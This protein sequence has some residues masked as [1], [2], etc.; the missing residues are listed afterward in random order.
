MLGG[1]LPASMSGLSA[2]ES[3]SLDGSGFC[4]PNSPAMQT[5]VAAIADFT[6]AVCEGSASFSRMVTPMF[7]LDPV[8]VSAVVDLNGD[9]RDDILGAST[10]SSAPPLPTG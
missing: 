10:W 5:W 7:G 2:L 9:G 4:V 1:P 6:G 3:L 8:S